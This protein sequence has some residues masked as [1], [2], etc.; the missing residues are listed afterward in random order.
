LFSNIGFSGFIL[1]AIFALFVFG[2]SKLPQIGRA[3]GLALREFKDATRGITNDI[4]EEIKEDIKRAKEQA[5]K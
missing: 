1:L 4:Q 3:V 5:P 2:P